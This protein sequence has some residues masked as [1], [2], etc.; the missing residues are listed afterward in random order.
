MYSMR[1]S[2]FYVKIASEKMSK[3]FIY[4]FLII[5]MIGSVSGFIQ[6]LYT[7]Y[8]LEDII[9][10]TKSDSFPDFSFSDGRFTIDR[11]E[12]I[13]YEYENYYM[14]IVDPTNTKTINDLAGYD[15][16]YLLQPESLY[17]STIG[18]SPKRYDLTLLKGLDFDKNTLISYTESIAPFMIPMVAIFSIIFILIST[19]FKSLF[20]YIL[21]IMI[22]SMNQI[23]S[24][25]NGKIY[26]M[27]LY[28]MSL[29]IIVTELLSLILILTPIIQI[30]PWVSSILPFITF[31][32]PSSLLLSKGLKAYKA[33]YT[34]PPTLQ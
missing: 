12:P 24:L 6:G 30:S 4:M 17:I 20:L 32:L 14:F 15:A 19:L 8:Q 33:K 31:Y 27:V 2:D 18:N 5:F 3:A 28:A 29:G 21:G 16:G 9:T 22:R 34:T 7:Y 1:S 11:N 23:P 13:V 26:K 10:I 25:S